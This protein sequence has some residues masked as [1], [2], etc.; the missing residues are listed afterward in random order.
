MLLKRLM[1]QQRRDKKHCGPSDRVKFKTSKT[2]D[3]K[4]KEITDKRARQRR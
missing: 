1:H 2:E 3:Y 4:E